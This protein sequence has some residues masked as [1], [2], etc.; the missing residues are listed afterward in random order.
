VW[1]SRSSSAAGLALV[2]ALAVSAPAGAATPRVEAQLVT[3]TGKVYGPKQVAVAGARVAGCRL[4]AGLP[5]DVLA[6]LRSAAG[7]PSFRAR[8]GC[9]ALYVFQ[10][11]RER[12]RGA[13]GW[14]Y[15]VGHKLP[16]VGASEPSGRLK[17][18]EQVTWFW[19]VN[20]SRCQRTLEVADAQTAGDQVTVTVMS[21]DDRGRAAPAEGAT[22][23]LGAARTTTDADGRAT[24]TAPAGATRVSA[25]K[26]GLV[27]AFPVEIA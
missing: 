26:K 6:A 24:L 2:A 21:Y 18:G 12:E 4:R 20:A 3:R 16:S 7:A 15:K 5:I 13:G 14:V 8:G 11:G 1:S 27:P 22:V 25:T 10:V 23:A 9:T 19:C 17:G